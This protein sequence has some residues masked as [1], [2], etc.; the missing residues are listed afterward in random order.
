VLIRPATGNDWRRLW[1]LWRAVVA[2][3]DSY[4]YAPDTAK[5]AARGLWMLQPPAETWL[6]EDG[7]DRPALGTYLLKPN[8]PG[9]GAHVANA[10][11]MV[12]PDA[13]GQGIGRLL[14]LHCLERAREIGYLAMQFNAVVSSNAP[15]IALW[16]SLGFDTVG[17]VPEAFRHPQLGLV[18][19]LV[20]HRRL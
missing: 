20:M 15:A 7:P 14:G 4:T 12:S 16:R 6:A 8:H 3:G 5:A 10:G 1:P 17:R 11:F 19:L 18:D 2:A 9:P 13:R